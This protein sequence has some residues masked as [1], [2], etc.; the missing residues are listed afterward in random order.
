MID[1][2]VYGFEVVDLALTASQC[3]HLAASLPPI[4]PGRG[5]IRG[6]VTH[7]AVLEVLHHKQLAR[8]IWATVGRELVAVK[9]TLF[10][11]TAE[12]N[13]RVAWHQDRVVAV[14]ERMDVAGYGRWSVKCGVPHVEP[15]AAVL[16]QMLA[17]RVYLD[18]CGSDN[19][20]LRVLPS[21]HE[22]GVLD[23]DAIRARVADH[24]PADVH[25]AKGALLFMRP[26]LVHSSSLARS[27]EHRRVLHLEFAPA[28]AISPLQWHTAIPLRRVA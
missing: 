20:P 25:V 17:V 16:A 15:P 9:A 4:A 14:R 13:W 28:E 27:T 21:S 11:K 12:S 26:L 10:D 19:G 22:S 1:F 6:L 18:A 5:G 3:D 2:D 23:E 24:T 8:R 7:P